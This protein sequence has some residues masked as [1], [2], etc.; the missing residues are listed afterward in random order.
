MSDTIHRVG[1]N[2]Y[3]VYTRQEADQLKLP[4][5]HW[6]AAIG[7]GWALTDDGYVLQVRSRKVYP[8]RDGETI[9]VSFFGNY[10]AFVTESGTFLWEPRRDRPRIRGAGMRNLTEADGTKTV[11]RE[12]IQVYCRMRLRGKIDWPKLVEMYGEK[13][14]FARQRLRKL[15]KTHGAKRMIRQELELLLSNSGITRQTVIDDLKVARQLAIDSGDSRK[16]MEVTKMLA[17]LTDLVP[18]KDVRREVGVADL[19]AFAAIID[20]HRAEK[21]QLAQFTDETKSQNEP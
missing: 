14:P 6:K 10:H 19:T 18:D 8:H 21:A 12:I 9:I 1:S 16:V 5:V 3:Q 11:I 15:L 13:V 4:Y 2:K 7:L 20:G 17:E